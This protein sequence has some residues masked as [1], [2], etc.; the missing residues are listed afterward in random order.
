MYG[1]V[2]GAAEVGVKLLAHGWSRFWSC[3]EYDSLRIFEQWENRVALVLSASDRPGKQP[4]AKRRK[5][6][7]V[8][9]VTSQNS[10]KLLL[11]DLRSRW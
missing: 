4:R 8:S 10:A 11:A 7:A 1:Y 2:F 3:A 5:K 6:N 9:R